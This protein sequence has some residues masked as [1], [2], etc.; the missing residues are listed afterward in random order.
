VSAYSAF[1]RI[2]VFLQKLLHSLN[3]LPLPYEH[4]RDSRSGSAFKWLRN[5][6]SYDRRRAYCSAADKVV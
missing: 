2:P 5:R 4:R 6:A 1:M 3:Q